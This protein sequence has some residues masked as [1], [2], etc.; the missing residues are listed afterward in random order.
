MF[1]WKIKSKSFP[2]EYKQ[3]YPPGSLPGKFYGTAKIDKLSQCDQ[4]EKLLIIPIISSIDTSTC[5]L[6]KHL[7]K[8]LSSLSISQI[9]VKSIKDFIQKLRTVKVLKGHQMVSFDVKTLF[10]NVP[11]EYIID[12]VL[13]QIYEIH[14]TSTSI[15]RNDV[16]EILLLCKNNVPFTFRDVVYFETDGVAMGSPL[17]SVLTRIF[18][19]HLESS[20]VPLLT[21]ELSFW[22][23]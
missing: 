10:T 11:L 7:A 20:L 5:R 22:K 23:W 4:V 16:R 12:L 1:Y 13:K 18:M 14:E 19:V 17:E 2:N 21:G 9:T 6:A 3:L 15:T 8:L